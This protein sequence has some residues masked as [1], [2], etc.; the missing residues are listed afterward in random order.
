MREWL[1]LLMLNIKLKRLENNYR[2]FQRSKKYKNLN[3]NEKESEDQ[4]YYQIEYSPAWEE[5]KEIKTN[6][7]LRKLRKFDVPYPSKWSKEG[8]DIWNEGDFGSHYL[9]TEGFYKLRS[10]LREEQKARREYW[11]GWVP[12][13]TALAAFISSATAI[14]TIIRYW[15]K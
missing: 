13:I 8:K 1:R 9:T 10:I 12:L 6:R 15:G 3:H 11:F 4:A 2:V 14:I 5:I 7:F